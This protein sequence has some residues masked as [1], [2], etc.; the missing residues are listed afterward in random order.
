MSFVESKWNSGKIGLEFFRALS[1]TGKSSL[2]FRVKYVFNYWFTSV[3]SN[4]SA[5]GTYHGHHS[6][7]FQNFLWPES[8]TCCRR[9]WRSCEEWYFLWNRN[10]ASCTELMRAS[11]SAWLGFSLMAAE[12]FSESC[13]FGA[14]RKKLSTNWRNVSR[15]ILSL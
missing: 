8:M 9:Y 10:K 14:S 7:I 6:K 1:I 11:A 15:D 4:L 3:F 12:S 13:Y 2:L 5:I